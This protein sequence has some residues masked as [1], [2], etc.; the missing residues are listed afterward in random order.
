VSAGPRWTRDDSE[1]DRA[2]GFVDATFALALTLLVTTIDVGDV[3]RVWDSPSTLGHE[4]GPQFLAFLISFA[5]IALYWLANHRLVASFVAID[6]PLIVA[7]LALIAAVVVLPFS[8]EAVGSPN[9]DDLPLP[10]AVLAVNVALASALHTLVYVLAA[11]RGL[12]AAK[13]SRDQLVA[14]VVKG[15]V[16]AVVFLLSIPLAY[17]TTP[18][19]A[20]VFWLAYPL[21]N[22]LLRHWGGDQPLASGAPASPD[23]PS[24]G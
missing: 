10:T 21:I 2:I 13:P 8:T 4:V 14:N 12:M 1:F 7:N 15:L 17:A 9:V 18:G 3:R 5:V 19:I 11:R 23:E 24:R 20:Q 22:W 6:T 16:P